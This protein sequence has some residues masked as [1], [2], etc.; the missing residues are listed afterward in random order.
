[1]LLAK[2]KTNYDHWG[3]FTVGD[4]KTYSKLEA[5]ELSA[6]LGHPPVWHFNDYVYDQFDWSQEPPGDLLFWYAQR[7]QQLR[8]TY[9]YLVIMYS[10][11]ADSHNMLRAFVDNNIFVDEIVQI[12]VMDSTGTDQTAE[13]N[14]ESFLTS[15]PQTKALIENNPVYRHTKHT[16]IDGGPFMTDMLDGVNMFDYWYQTSNLY[17]SP[18]GHMVG[19]VREIVSQYQ[20]LADQGRTMCFVWGVN[21]PDVEIINNSFHIKISESGASAL[22]PPKRQTENAAWEHDEMFY[23][24]ADMPELLAKQG[25][26]IK[27]FID[28]FDPTL[29]DNNWVRPY[30]IPDYEKYSLYREGYRAV[31]SCHGKLLELTENGVHGLIYPYWKSGTV[32]TPK[33]PSP[34]FGRKD[35][36]LWHSN[37]PS[38]AL[39]TYFKGVPWL[40]N[41]I[42][43]LNPDFWWEKP[44]DPTKAAYCGGMLIFERLLNFSKSKGDV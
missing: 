13:A 25:H 30:S 36:W 31:F 43:N 19:R 33:P 41:H 16:L 20:N 5:F 1:M 24:T 6:K 35:N 44:Y 29:V 7:A 27:R 23:W 32:T 4:L 3:Y 8:D 37:V 39:R 12:Y 38:A 14:K 42:R 9:D 28:R 40:R 2:P 11:G 34:F 21:K 15:I 18:W 22:V 17:F 10:G 26:V